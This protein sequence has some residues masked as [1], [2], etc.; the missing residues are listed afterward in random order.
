[1]HEEDAIF[2]LIPRAHNGFGAPRDDVEAWHMLMQKGRRLQLG[3]APFA[4]N[5][6]E[7]VPDVVLTLGDEAFDQR[8]MMT[9][10]IGPSRQRLARARIKAPIV[11]GVSV[12]DAV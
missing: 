9:L 1:M 3:D 7:I 12:H 4:E 11:L 6:D 8:N 2:C 10:R 5:S